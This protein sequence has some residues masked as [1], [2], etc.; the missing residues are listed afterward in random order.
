MHSKT[1]GFWQIN[2][3]EFLKITVNLNATA[4]LNNQQ[5]YSQRD[6]QVIQ[7]ICKLQSNTDHRATVVE[8]QIQ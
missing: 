4:P 2:Q 5:L 8:M 6:S 7:I 1:N 3:L